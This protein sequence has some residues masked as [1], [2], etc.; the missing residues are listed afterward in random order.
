MGFTLLQLYRLSQLMSPERGR[1]F[2]SILDASEDP[3]VWARSLPVCSDCGLPGPSEGNCALL[4]RCP[5][6]SRRGPLVQHS[7]KWEAK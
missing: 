3:V 5:E 6:C 1:V 2:R 4:C 7:F